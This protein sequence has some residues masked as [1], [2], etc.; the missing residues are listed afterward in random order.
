MT[1]MRSHQI[2]TKA[3]EKFDIRVFN[4]A[5]II[6]KEY[7][8]VRQKVKSYVRFSSS[9]YVY[10]INKSAKKNRSLKFVSFSPKKKM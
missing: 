5:D 1:K 2:G 4:T 7:K 6:L 8:F 3:F 9:W 10:N